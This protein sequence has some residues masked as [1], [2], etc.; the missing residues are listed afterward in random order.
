MIERSSDVDYFRLQTAQ[1]GP[2]S[3]PA[4]PS[5][6]YRNL[7]IK[8]SIFNSSGSLITAMNPQQVLYC[9]GRNG[10]DPGIY[11]VSVEGEGL[12]SAGFSENG[13]NDY[14]SI[15]PYSLSGNYPPARR[16]I[17]RTGM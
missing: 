4:S 10:A 16:L 15:G 12:G 3:V 5:A 2:I 13:Y 1:A 7:D 9:H 11:Y 14:G 8:L 6:D 17:R